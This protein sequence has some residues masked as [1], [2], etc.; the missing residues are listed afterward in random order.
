[1]PTKEL[2][3]NTSSPVCVTGATGY[4][5]GVLI[6]ELLK[7][8][9]TVHAT[10]RDP[11]Q[12]DRL[13]YLQTV[14]D[15]LPGALKFY[16][17][18]LLDKGSFHEAMKGCS[19]VFHTASP[20]V[21]KVEDP[22]KDLIEPAVHGTENVLTAVNDTPSVKRVVL[23]SSVVAMKT[24]A[25][26]ADEAPGGVLNEDAWNRTATLATSPYPL[27]KTMAEQK[28]WVMAGSQSR[29]SM[30]TIH[31][32][33][34]VGP[35]LKYHASSTSYQLV[36][37]LADGTMKTGVPNLALSAVDVREVAH[38]H[39]AAAYLPE[40][41]GRYIVNA[42]DTTFPEM[43]N[44]L[45]D[46]FGAD[47]PIPASTVP[48]LLVWMVA[49]YLPGGLTREYISR[50]VDRGGKMDN[51]KSIR[52]LGLEYRP[53]KESMEEMMQQMIDAGVFKKEA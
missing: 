2:K 7:I 15:G 43:A 23:T 39:V 4:V 49:P 6:Q 24:D 46:K 26:D 27:S 37:Q 42:M 28:A 8:G 17:A 35:G 41:S 5:A 31:P 33:L 1:M 40:A 3:V 53:V 30:A 21:M 52:E 11:S 20:F 9:V 48:K 18:D 32:G 22:T 19:I 10:C 14:A 29:W 36:K 25:A 45:R 38:A 34:V 51:T 47:Y 50:N 13:A 16:K 12:K 44:M